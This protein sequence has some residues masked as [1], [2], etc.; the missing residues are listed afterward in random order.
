MI[1]K[2]LTISSLSARQSHLQNERTIKTNWQRA[3][4]PSAFALPAH[5]R[6]TCGVALCSS[7]ISTRLIPN[8]YQHRAEW[9]AFQDLVPPKFL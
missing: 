7:I 2:K 6:G 5:R 3:G 1:V 4:R 8:Q 9:T